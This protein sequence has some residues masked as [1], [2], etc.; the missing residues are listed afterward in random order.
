MSSKWKKKYNNNSLFLSYILISVN[1][2][3][4]GFASLL[5]HCEIYSQHLEQ[6]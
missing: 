6:N 4:I 2:D 5:N 1:I 3:E